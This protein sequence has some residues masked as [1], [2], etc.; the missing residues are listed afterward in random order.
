MDRSA[1]EA[2]VAE[3]NTGVLL[4]LRKGGRPQA[5]NIVYGVS[6]GVIRISVTAGRAKTRNLARD[7]RATLHVTSDDFWRWVAVDATAELSAVSTAP[8]DEVGRELAELFELVQGKPHPDW[9]DFYRA[10]VAD[11]RLVVR[12]RPEHLYGQLG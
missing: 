1:A 12:L 6:D 7:S 2:F 10:M 8:G 3:R 5:S 4:T 9:D 11:Q